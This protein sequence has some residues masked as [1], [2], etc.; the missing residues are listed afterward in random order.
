RR[1]RRRK[2]RCEAR[3]LHECIRERHLIVLQHRLP[4]RLSDDHTLANR[5]RVRQ[6]FTE[7]HHGHRYTV[8]TAQGRYATALAISCFVK[9]LNQVPRLLE[10][11]RQE[12]RGG[13]VDALSIDARRLW[14]A[15]IDVA[16]PEVKAALIGHPAQK[17]N[18]LIFNK[19]IGVINGNKLRRVR[20][21]PHTQWFDLYIS[22]EEIRR[23]VRILRNHSERR[24]LPEGAH[25]GERD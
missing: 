11:Y 16:R 12:I 22:I 8:R 13:G 7:A 19:E 2:R 20:T 3:A 15:V 9:T 10:L 6:K 5:F 1:Q 25:A 21:R 4:T 18:V 17:V 23:Q 14:R 24:T